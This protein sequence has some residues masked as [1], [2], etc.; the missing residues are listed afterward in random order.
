[1]SSDCREVNEATL[2]ARATKVRMGREA[3][4]EAA[5]EAIVE[6]HSEWRQPPL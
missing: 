3:D 6:T 2:S 4:T 1:M 5:F